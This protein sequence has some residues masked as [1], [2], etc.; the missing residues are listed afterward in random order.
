MSTNIN[1]Q[2]EYSMDAALFHKWIQK[3]T[4]NAYG[5]DYKN[6]YID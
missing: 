2:I 6:E 1:T 4:Q 5:N 3:L